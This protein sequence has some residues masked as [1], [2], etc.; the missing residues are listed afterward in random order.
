MKPKPDLDPDFAADPRRPS[1]PVRVMS[2]LVLAAI[3]AGMTLFALKPAPAP[4]AFAQGAIPV[5]TGDTVVV[6]HPAEAE[7]VMV[8]APQSGDRFV[9]MADAN[10]DPKMVFPAP[11]GIDDAMVHRPFGGQVAP[12]VPAEP[13]P[14]DPTLPNY[15]PIPRPAPTPDGQ[16]APKV[17]PRVPGRSQPR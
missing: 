12:R 15:E 14:V 13:Q 4:P 1:A 2:V 9:L 6:A 8:F 10:I 3:V 11:E 16:V 17:S 5:F 7:P